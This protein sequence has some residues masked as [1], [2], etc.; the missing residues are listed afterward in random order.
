[1]KLKSWMQALASAGVRNS[2]AQLLNQ[3][4]CLSPR[5]RDVVRETISVE[6]ECPLHGEF[7]KEVE[8][9]LDTIEVLEV[10][11]ALR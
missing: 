7:A 2:D 1:M 3:M 6:L 11:A 9:T 4:S 5:Q 8:L 10:V